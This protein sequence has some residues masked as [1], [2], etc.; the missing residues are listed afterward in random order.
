MLDEA[1][2]GHQIGPLDE[3]LRRVPA[4]EYQVEHRRFRGDELEHLV[5]RD[6]I[7]VDRAEDLVEHDDFEGAGGDGLARFHD[8]RLRRGHVFLHRDPRV[9]E[10]L[11]REAEARAND[12]E[13][14]RERL[15]RLH[16]A[17]LPAYLD[18][19]DDAHVHAI[20]RRPQRE[21]HR[22]GRLPLPVAG[23]DD[24]EAL[25]ALLGLLSVTHGLP[26]SSGWMIRAYA[27]KPS[28]RRGPGRETRSSS[29]G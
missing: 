22:R 25:S 13:E 11:D 4:G 6:E 26:K 14:G 1:H 3:R 10:P 20:A 19:L 29:I 17:G 8:P 21:A 18:E 5:E 12:L 23:E 15:D 2:L 28:T 27:S 16:L 7:G 24:D 9:A